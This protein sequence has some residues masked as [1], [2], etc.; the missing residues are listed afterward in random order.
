METTGAASPHPPSG[1]LLP[2]AGEGSEPVCPAAPACASNESNPESRIPN[3][4]SRI[5]N[6]ESRIPNPES[7]IPNPESR[8]PN[9]GP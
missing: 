6:P 8:I 1:H 3:P 7:R 2:R 9:P 4:E 5:P